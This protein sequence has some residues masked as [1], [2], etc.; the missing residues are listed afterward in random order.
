MG[1]SIC[2][3]VLGEVDAPSPR[4]SLSGKSVGDIIAVE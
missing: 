1:L 4:T 3:M 2:N